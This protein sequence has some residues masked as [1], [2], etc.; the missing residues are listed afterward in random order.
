MTA[1]LRVTSDDFC[2]GAVFKPVGRTQ[3]VCI[4]AAPKLAGLMHMGLDTAIRRCRAMGWAVEVIHEAPL[5]T[6]IRP[7]DAEGLPAGRG[8][9]I[10]ASDH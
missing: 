7:V 10:Q 4:E 2:A 5:M 6:W 3:F 8:R 1:I 9:L